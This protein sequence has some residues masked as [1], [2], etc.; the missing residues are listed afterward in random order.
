MKNSLSIDEL[1]EYIIFTENTRVIKKFVYKM[2]PTPY[3]LFVIKDLQRDIN[4][5]KR[6]YIERTGC[7]CEM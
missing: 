2:L 6:R 4:L 1:R 7:E 3:R 5:Y